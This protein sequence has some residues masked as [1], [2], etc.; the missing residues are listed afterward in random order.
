MFHP[1]GFVTDQ[2]TYIYWDDEDDSNANSF[3]GVLPDGVYD[4]NTRIQFCC[5]GDGVTSLGMSLPTDNTFYLFASS[6]TC[7]EV[8]AITMMMMMMIITVMIIITMIK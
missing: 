7:Q 8:G 5:R 2:D 3:G 4:R 6:S 1:S